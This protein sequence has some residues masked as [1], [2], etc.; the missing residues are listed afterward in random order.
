MAAQLDCLAEVSQLPNVA[1]RIAPFSVG[2]HSGMQS[3]SFEIL[4]F[5]LN[6]SG[7]DSEPPTVYAEQY[8]GVLYLDKP[9][10]VARYDQAFGRIWEVALD[11]NVSRALLHEAAEELR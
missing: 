7:E 10:E 5:P 9:H 8:T 3:G 1:L 6:G 2:L 4:R 11:E